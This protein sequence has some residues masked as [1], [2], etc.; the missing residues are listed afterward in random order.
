MEDQF[1]EA[2]RIKLSNALKMEFPA[3]IRREQPLLSVPGRAHAITGMRRAGKTFYLFQCLRD[4][5]AQGV[6]RERLV[7]F[8][9][10][11]IRLGRLG[12]LEATH[13]LQI[14]EAYYQRF[15]GFRG[16]EEVV[17]CFDEI[18]LVQEWERFV[19]LLIDSE[20]VRVFFSGSSAKML[21]REVATS[22][23][24][25]AMETTITPFNFREFASA[26]GM[27]EIDWGGYPSSSARSW[28][29]K[30]LDDYLLIGGLPELTNVT[31]T[32]VWDNLLQDHIENVLSR[33]VADRH[34]IR[35]VGLL[36]AFARQL[37]CNL[38]KAFSVS[39]ITADFSSRGLAVS[40]DTLL[41]FLG[42]FEDA[43]L[44]STVEIFS[45]SE[46]Q[47]QVNP[48]KLYLAD[49]SLARAFSPVAIDRGRMLENIVACELAREMRDLAYVKT[50]SGREVDFIATA[51]DGSRHLIQVASD[52]SAPKTWEREVK[53]LLEAQG[54]V[55]DARLWLLCEA[56]PPANFER[57]EK[58][59]VIPL[60]QWL[61]VGIAGFQRTGWGTDWP[62]AKNDE[63]LPDE[64]GG[65]TKSA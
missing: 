18:Q 33:D 62:P 28:L 24:G 26:R 41:A 2:V 35:S 52:V 42:Y 14:L 44:V 8:S 37:L 55:K 11:D 5:L 57:P 60:Y 53:P 7:Y 39:K 31:T 16:K 49:H 50:A 38:A 17:F 32:H 46:R 22:M 6:A 65:G 43:F 47:R 29:Q 9:L 3:G 51:Y 19:R 40:K 20:K 30:T 15:P 59:N 12:S 27:P 61:S 10:E 58:I 64:K 34:N 56:L 25:R 13:L 21:S 48:R 23:R 36:D 54:E 63:S 45:R 4:A 1:M